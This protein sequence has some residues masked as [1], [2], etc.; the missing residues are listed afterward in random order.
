[1]KEEEVRFERECGMTTV[2]P[3][4]VLVGESTFCSHS[5]IAFFVYTTTSN[6]GQ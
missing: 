3:S 2:V 6:Q 5:P 1:M 4:D